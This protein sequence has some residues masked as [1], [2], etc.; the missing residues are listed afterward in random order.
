[1]IIGC[2]KMKTNIRKYKNKTETIKTESLNSN[3]NNMT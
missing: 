1:M 2:F 3:N